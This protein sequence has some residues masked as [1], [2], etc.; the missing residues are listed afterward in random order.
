MDDNKDKY[1]TLGTFWKVI[2]GIT[3]LSL[4]IA[5]YLFSQIEGTKGELSAYKDDQFRV[6]SEIQKDVQTVL[7]DVGW[8]RSFLSNV[9]TIQE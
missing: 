7:T 5:G 6:I 8:L 9:E 3:A 2:G 4:I 1:V